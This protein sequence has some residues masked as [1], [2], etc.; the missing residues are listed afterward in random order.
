MLRAGKFQVSAPSGP[1]PPPAGV[2]PFPTP[3]DK[4]HKVLLRE[5]W[6]PRRAYGEALIPAQR[7]RASGPASGR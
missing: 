5:K 1:F 6:Y 2:S 3:P 4:A 7:V